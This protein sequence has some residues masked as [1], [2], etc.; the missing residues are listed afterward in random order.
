VNVGHG[1]AV[2]FGLLHEFFVEVHDAVFKVLI[3]DFQLAN[4]FFL[5]WARG[6]GRAGV[7]GWP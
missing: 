5:L 4:L 3:C 6:E 1:A 2:V 7:T